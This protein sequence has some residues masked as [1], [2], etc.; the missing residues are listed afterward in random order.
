MGKWI[1]TGKHL[2]DSFGEEL[3]LDVCFGERGVGAKDCSVVPLDR[4]FKLVSG[5]LSREM[6][7]LS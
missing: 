1:G 2:S 3:K 6:R 4:G 7:N 5:E